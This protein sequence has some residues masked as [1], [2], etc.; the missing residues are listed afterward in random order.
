MWPGHDAG[1]VVA[2]TADREEIAMK[3]RVVLAFDG[4]AAA[5]AAIRAAASLMPG[6]DATVVYVRGEP[7]PLEPPAV[8]RTGVP[9]E[10]PGTRLRDQERVVQDRAWEIAERGSAIAASSGLRATAEVRARRTAWRALCDAG[11]D[12]AA[13]VIVCGNRGRGAL[14]RALGSTSSSLLHHADRPILIVTGDAA[15]ADGPMLIGYDG[16]DGARAAIAAA[17]RLLASRPA[18]IAHAWSTPQQASYS[19]AYALLPAPEGE[20]QAAMERL[21]RIRADELAEEGVAYAA[22]HGL[23]ARALTTNDQAGA[24]RELVAAADAEQAAA[25]VVGCRGHGAI[26]GTLL[27]SVSAGLAHHADVPVLVVHGT[28]A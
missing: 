27:G 15:R 17:A 26:A 11:L 1:N 23:P 28:R 13:D 10:A 2:M 18:V 7:A 21:A 6:A 20:E 8:V 24:W 16:S 12:H 22:E 5:A 4:S 14:S 25:I 9:D 19:E 3:P